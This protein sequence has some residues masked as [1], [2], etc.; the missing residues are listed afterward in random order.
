MTD[1]PEK[2]NAVK[3]RGL[4]ADALRRLFKNWMAVFGLIVVILVSSTSILADWI[5]PFDPSYQQRWVGAKPPGHEQLSVTNE[6]RVTVGSETDPRNLSTFLEGF[7][8]DETHEISLVAHPPREL[9]EIWIKIYKSRKYPD[10]APKV[11]E[12]FFPTRRETLDELAITDPLHTLRVTDPLPKAIGDEEPEPFELPGGATFRVKKKIDASLL[13]LV[14][15]ERTAIEWFGTSAKL[16]LQWERPAR[17]ENDVVRIFLRGRRIEKIL[18][19]GEP[20]EGFS[21]PGRDIEEATLDGEPMVHTHLFGTDDVGRD[22]LSRVLKGGQISL[23]VGLIATLVSVTIG[24]AVGATSGFLSDSQ[25]SSASMLAGAAATMAACGIAGVAIGG[26]TPGAIAAIVVLVLFV[27]TSFVCRGE[28]GLLGPSIGRLLASPLTT[29]DGLLMRFVD[30]IYTLPYM[31]VVILLM[32]V[33]GRNLFVLFAALGAVQWLTMARI[34]RGQ[35]LSLKRKEFVDAA[36]VSGASNFSIIFNH[37][38]PNVLGVVAVYTTLTIPAVILQESFLAFIGLTVQV[39]GEAVES[40]GALINY[41]LNQLEDGGGRSWLLLIPA[42]FMSVTLFGLNFL[43]DGLRD[44][45]DPRMR[46]KS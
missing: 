27:P 17:S 4:W 21:A 39:D 8:P 11:R 3:S 34:V 24:V 38:V 13:P 29:V 20:V 9:E 36:E 33:F 30:I 15:P 25:V 23:A 6:V 5:I 10:R 16:I 41:G 28:R 22:V 2:A 42:A 40:W 35:T 19:N 32:V 37:I 43:G 31:F 1:A 18:M 12:I 46:G 14:D 26:S 44:A 45:L 7:G